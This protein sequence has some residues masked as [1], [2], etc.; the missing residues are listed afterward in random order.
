MS[1]F[2]YTA[3]NTVFRNFLF[4]V[5]LSIL[6]MMIMSL[7]TAAQRFRK[8]AFV[9]PE[10]IIPKKGKT[11]LPTTS[12]PDVERVRRNHLND[13]E[14]I[15]P[16]VL[17]GLCYAACN[18]DSNVSLWHFRIFFF[19]RI[20]HTISYQ[21]SLP[22]PSRVVTFFIGLIVTVSMAIQTLVVS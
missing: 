11:V 20:L 12:D 22:H 18:P 19:S 3:T 13:I 7:L 8:D 5:I 9:N 21:L 6:K 16:F 15:I 1:T 14:N 2:Y 4:Y 10:D 17:I